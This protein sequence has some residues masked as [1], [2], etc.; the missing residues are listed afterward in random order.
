MSALLPL[1]QAI[2]QGDYRVLYLAWLQAAAVSA[3]LE[4][5]VQEPPVL[6]NLQKFSAPLQSFVDWVEMDMDL[7]AA[8]AQVSQTEQELREPFKE[9]V[10]AL[11]DKEKTKLLVEIITG[12]S[13]IASQLQARL[14]QK[15]SQPPELPSISDTNRR[16]FSELRDLAKTRRSER[17]EKEKAAVKA[18]R[19]RY[20]ESLRPQRSQIW[21]TVEAL[22]ARKQAKPY[23]QA[24]HRAISF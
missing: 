5:D 20:L 17:Q 7:I 16:H 22:I 15:F 19:D 4:E 8:A 9:W 18:E 3:H 1:R 12:D 11:S 14:R 24:I 6:P 21:E 23:E 2:L 10:N 13:A